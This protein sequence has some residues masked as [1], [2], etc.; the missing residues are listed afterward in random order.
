MS[1]STAT[2]KSLTTFVKIERKQFDDVLRCGTPEFL[3]KLASFDDDVLKRAERWADDL[4]K[5]KGANTY[6]TFPVRQEKQINAGKL[7]LKA[8]ATFRQAVREELASRAA[9]SLFQAA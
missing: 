5:Q 3:A 2:E 9:A 1:T 4:R 7:Y 8:L 6:L